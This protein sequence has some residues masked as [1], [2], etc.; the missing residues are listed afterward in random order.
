MWNPQLNPNPIGSALR[1][2]SIFEGC[3]GG[4][5]F[6]ENIVLEAFGCL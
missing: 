3:F 5:Y 2:Q 6:G 4:V 1:I